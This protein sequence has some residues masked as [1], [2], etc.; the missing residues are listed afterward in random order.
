[1]TQLE[2]LKKIAT[3]INDSDTIANRFR[4][5]VAEPNNKRSSITFLIYSSDDLIF[6]GSLKQCLE[7]LN[8]LKT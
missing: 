6:E 2:I 8:L 4:I 7:F 3:S 1:M 5:S